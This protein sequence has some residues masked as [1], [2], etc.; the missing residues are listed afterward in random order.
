MDCQWAW[1]KS[2]PKIAFVGE[3]PSDEELL[4]GVPLV[5]ASGRKMGEILRTAGLAKPVEDIPWDFYPELAA[6]GLRPLLWE[7]SSFHWT[8]VFNEKLPDNEVK[9]WCSPATEAKNWNDYSLDRIA[10]AGF[11]RP[12]RSHHL[13]R[14]R[15]E[16]ELVNPT[17]I[18]PLGGTA[19][20]AFT[21]ES[22]IMAKRGAVAVAS[23]LL[24]GVKL[25]PTL[26]PANVIY[27]HKMFSVVVSDLEKAWEEAQFREVRLPKR[28]IWVEPTLE[29]LHDFK[30]RFIR[31]GSLLSTDIE[32]AG[33]QITCIGFAPGPER[34]IVIPFVDYRKSDRSYWPTAEAELAALGF[35]RELLEDPTIFKMFQ[36]GPYDIYWIWRY[37]RVRVMGYL[38]D[39]RL[40][41]HALYPE[42]PK[43]LQF[44]GATY[45]KNFAWKSTLRGREKKS[46]KRDE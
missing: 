18:V 11:L 7:R 4:E 37:W 6:R 32:T 46:D 31:S 1:K 17:L 19:L 12:D 14:L 24:P 29:D 10:N 23:H 33:G 35:V 27:S 22:D 38:H 21:G 39:T 36:N 5:G 13:D 28:E 26:H 15:K 42:L 41:H 44:M 9:N 34:A 20:W 43:S 25:L 45:G 2:N 30:K 40:M 16:L 8:N 3:A